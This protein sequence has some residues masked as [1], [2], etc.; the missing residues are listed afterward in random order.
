MLTPDSLIGRGQTRRLTNPLHISR[1]SLFPGDYSPRVDR[2]VIDIGNC[3]LCPFFSR[4][5]AKLKGNTN[6]PTMWSATF[7]T[8]QQP[9]YKSY[10][11]RI[12]MDDE[13]NHIN[14]SD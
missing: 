8:K 1:A 3:L 9:W 4:D 10:N 6:W 11:F 5:T 13:M 14:R 2:G 7:Y 12:Y